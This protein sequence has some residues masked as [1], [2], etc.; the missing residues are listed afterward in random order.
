MIAAPALKWI[1]A[2]YPTLLFVA[3]SGQRGTGDPETQIL[4]F[5]AAGHLKSQCDDL[6]SIPLK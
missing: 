1:I 3:N 2:L 6:S 4:I 5:P